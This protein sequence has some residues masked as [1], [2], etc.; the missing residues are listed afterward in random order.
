MRATLD[1]RENTSRVLNFKKALERHCK[2][3]VEISNL[4]IHQN[5]TEEK[6]F[7][8]GQLAFYFLFSDMYLPEAA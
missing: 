4:A 7:K 2:C 6:L 3:P 8:Q 5:E 1:H